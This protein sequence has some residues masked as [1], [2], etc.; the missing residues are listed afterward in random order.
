MTYYDFLNDYR[1]PDNE[2]VRQAYELGF[3]GRGVH[4]RPSGENIFY[5]TPQLNPENPAAYEQEGRN[6]LTAVD[7]ELWNRRSQRPESLLA[8]NQESL[9]RDY[10]SDANPPTINEPVPLNPFYIESTY[11]GPA[12][13]L[14]GPTG[15]IVP[16]FTVEMKQHWH[17][18]LQI[19]QQQILVLVLL[20]LLQQIWHSI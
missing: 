15:A 3:G 4:G 14:L 16:I 2:K 20:K 11:K 12:E 8:Q 1:L 17:K 19:Q 7:R 6:F 18:Q 10:I 13:G 9:L 5:D